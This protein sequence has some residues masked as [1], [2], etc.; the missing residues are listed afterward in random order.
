M[1]RLARAVA[2]ALVAVPPAVAAPGVATAGIVGTVV[3]VDDGDTI[4]VRIGARVVRVRYIG[5][6]APE[7]AHGDRGPGGPG[8]FAAARLNAALVGGR[9][10]R[11]ELDVERHDRYGRVLAY[12]WTGD[13]MLNAELV[14]RGYARAMPIAPNLRHAA[15]FAALE[16]EARAAR[17]GLWESGALASRDAGGER[18][19]ALRSDAGLVP[20]HRSEHLHVPPGA[21]VARVTHVRARLPER[22]RPRVAAL[23]QH[24]DPPRPSGPQPPLPLR[25]Q[26]PRHAAAAPFR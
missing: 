13:T 4:D 6:D 11:L 23:G 3:H 17:R 16:A 22:H 5:I 8:G 12:V 1:S 25:H 20:R 14:G 2:V 19:P 7:I 9:A 15:R 24:R 26:R 18:A 10:V 21:G